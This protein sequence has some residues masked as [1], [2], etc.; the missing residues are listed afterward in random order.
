MASAPGPFSRIL[1]VLGPTNTGKTHFAVERMLAHRGGLIGFP[2]RLL[3][4]EIYDRIVQARGPAQVALIT[5][6]EKLG[7][8]TAPYV[9]ATVEAMPVERPFPFLAVDEIQLCADHERGHVFTDRLLHARGT[10][11]TM[12]L[13]SATI[14]HVL[15]RLVPQAEI[16]TRPRFSTLSHIGP[17]KLTRLPRRSAIVAFSAAE[18]YALAEVVRRQRGGTAVVMGALSPRTR[19]A[20]VAMYQAGEVDHLVATDAI[21]MGLNMDLAHVAFAELH[22]FDG[23]MRRRLSTPEIGQIAGRAGRH[24]TDGTFGTTNG[25]GELDEAEVEAVE[26]HAF[27]PL[28]ALR[29]RAHDLAFSSLDGLLASLDAEPPARCLVKV[30]DAVDDRSLALLASREHI[31][32]VAD[33]EARIR[34]LWQVCQIPDFTKT[35]ADAH[36]H[37][38]ETVFRH[39]TGPSGVL[40]NDWVGASIAKLDRVDGDIDALV[41][42][43]AHVRTW[44]YMSHRADWL[45]D[46]AHWQGRA[47]E[48][49]DR[50]SDALHERLTQRFVD[51]RTSALIRSLRHGGELPAVVEPD[52]E[53]VVEGHGVGRI[54]G[55]EFAFATG[56]P[57]LDQRAVRS[58]ARRALAPALAKEA[59]RFLDAPDD[60]LELL[61]DATI[62]WRGVAVARLLRSAD[63]LRPAVTALA[64]D[65]LETRLRLRIEARLEAWLERW[66]GDRLR[67][68]RALQD[69]ARDAALGGRA[70]GVAYSVVEGWGVV[71][72]DTVAALLDVATAEDRAALA[73][74]GI[75]LGLHHLYLEPALKP[76]AIAARAILLGLEAGRVVAPPPVGAVVWR[77]LG[78]ADRRLAP[79]L[80]YAPA[81]DCAVRVDALERLGAAL[82]H[83]L[84]EQVRVALPPEIGASAGLRA[85]ELAAVLP[86]LGF[87]VLDEDDRRWLVRLRRPRGVPGAAS[88][89]ERARQ[90]RPDSPFAAIAGLRL[91]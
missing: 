84:R 59:A 26:G 90:G 33:R 36:L 55:F 5:G 79:A 35:L 15:K 76:A 27:P 81:G 16:L 49:E 28:Q 60:A 38:L 31:R 87:A 85:G 46:P 45:V 44:T 73:R 14:R 8:E 13:G 68:L 53:L 41:A 65:S 57:G 48:V 70:R 78:Q 3:A 34:L 43:I 19:N 82:R 1:A 83:L 74:L 39:L 51:K 71:P 12:F 64:S 30:R 63:R 42:R 9:V 80:G 2:L 18:V 77:G 91:G 61:P 25:A 22:K 67:P 32:R 24:M 40:P 50:L 29:W 7:P 89:R 72:R 52:G 88:R 10:E 20:Q 6:E 37:L 4:R 11:E 62:A 56:D 75:R 66:L 47:R 17:V 58:A 23:R 21:G 69:C 54:Q 86:G